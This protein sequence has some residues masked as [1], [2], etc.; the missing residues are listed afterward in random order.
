MKFAPQNQKKRSLNKIVQNKVYPPLCP[1]SD[2]IGTP[3]VEI[4]SI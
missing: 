1:G 4:E 2:I 3:L